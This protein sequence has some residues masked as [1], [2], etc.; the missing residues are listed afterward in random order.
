MNELD[1]SLEDVNSSFHSF[2]ALINEKYA[3]PYYSNCIAEAN[4][5]SQIR[6]AFPNKNVYMQ[7]H[8]RLLISLDGHGNSNSD[9]DRG[10]LICPCGQYFDIFSNQCKNNL[11]DTCENNIPSDIDSTYFKRKAMGVQLSLS[12]KTLEKLYRCIK[13]LGGTV[14][15]RNSTL[16]KIDCIQTDERFRN[17]LGELGNCF[18]SFLCHLRNFQKHSCMGFPH[19]AIF[20]ME[21][22]V[23]TQ[24]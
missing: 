1:S 8:F 22:F 18:N 15:R 21:G 16:K 2:F 20:Y 3:N 14:I 19:S 23:Q 9:T 11:L 24:K 7:P 4:L 12:L 10:N 13:Q 17:V 6:L 5:P